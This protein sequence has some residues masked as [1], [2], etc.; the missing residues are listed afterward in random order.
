MGRFSVSQLII[1]ILFCLLVFGDI[2]KMVSNLKVFLK[3]RKFISIKKKNRKK[4]T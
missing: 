4:G 2:P 1:F 3:K